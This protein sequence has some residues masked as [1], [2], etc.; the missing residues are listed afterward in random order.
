MR[1]IAVFCSVNELE[2]KYI[3]PAREFAKL[4]AENGYGL[5]WG[6]TDKGL[7]KVIADGVQEGGGKIIG[8]SMEIIKEHVRKDA[9]EMIIA[10]DLGERK[11]TFLKRCDAMTMLVGG[12]GTLDE[13]MHMLELKKHNMHNK[14][15]VVLN[16]ENFYEGLKVQLQKMKDDGFITKPLDEYLYFADTPKEAIQY[17]NEKLA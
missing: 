12:I 1:Y 10:K 6:G 17:L 15:L 9:D 5:I 2:E 13:V 16:T 14:P 4:L 7:M 8:I 3:Q 11:A